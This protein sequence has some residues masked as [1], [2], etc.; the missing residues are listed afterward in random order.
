MNMGYVGEMVL[1]KDAKNLE[2]T[3]KKELLNF[4]TL[5]FNVNLEKDYIN[6]LP[7]Q[8]QE[9]LAG[10]LQM[11]KVFGILEEN[12]SSFSFDID[13]KGKRLMLN[14]QDRSEMLQMIETGLLGQGL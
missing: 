8:L 2:A 6:N 13:Y 12:N 9:E 14:G 1:P 11:A 10:Q 7:L 5:D 3:F 4:I